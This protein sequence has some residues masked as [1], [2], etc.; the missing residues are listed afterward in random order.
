MMWRLHGQRLL[1]E[2]GQLDVVPKLIELVKNPAVDAIGTNGGALH[3]L[4]TLHG[5]GALEQRRPAP[6]RRD[7]GAQA[8]GR[9]RRGKPRPWC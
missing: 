5:L 2:R 7:R 4:W 8:Q 9:R 3:A 1:I 6:H